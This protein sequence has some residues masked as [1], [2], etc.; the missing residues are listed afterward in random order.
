MTGRVSFAH[1]A[2]LSDGRGIFEHAAGSVPRIEGGYCLDDTARALIVVCREP[3]PSRELRHLAAVYFDFVLDAQAPTGACHNRLDTLGRWQDEPGV[4]DWWGRSQWALGTAAARSQDAWIRAT[5]ATRFDRGAK[6][7]SPDRRAMAFAALGAAE[8][9]SVHNGHAPARKLL[10]DAAARIGRPAS[11]PAWPWPEPRLAYA[12]GAIA[13]ALIAAGHYL[14]DR[15]IL[16]DGLLLLGWLLET[17]TYEG[18]LSVSPVGGRGPG[19][20]RPAFDQ[21]PIEVAAI[22]DACVRALDITGDPRWAAG[23]DLAVRWFLGANDRGVP[24]SDAAT[25]AGFD[26]LTVEGRNANQGAESTLAMVATMQQAAHLPAAS[27]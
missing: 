24:M 22:A 8:L 21:Q 26:A 11:D 3:A 12:N 5:A 27:R 2:R 6:Q 23:L 16:D 19:D 15:T 18:H 7:R 10:A 20:P 4:G 14:D 13:E 1:V 17:E 9:L 25:G